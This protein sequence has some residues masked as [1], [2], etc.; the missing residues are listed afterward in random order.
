[1]EKKYVNEIIVKE[2]T[3]DNGGGL[4]RVS[5]KV[6]ELI[7]TLKEIEENGWANLCIGKR[8]TPSDKGVTHYAYVDEW[9]PNKSNESMPTNPLPF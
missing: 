5:V 7:E 9:K 6:P 3:F 1:M 8:Q 4:L 2:K